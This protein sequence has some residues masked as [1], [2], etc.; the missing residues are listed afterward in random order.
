MT[1]IFFFRVLVYLPRE[2]TNISE[3]ITG[4]KELY[5]QDFRYHIPSTPNHRFR[6]SFN[7]DHLSIT[8]ASSLPHQFLES[9]LKPSVTSASFFVVDPREDEVDNDAVFL[10][11]FQIISSQAPNL[12]KLEIDLQYELILASHHL[13][14]MLTNHD[15]ITYLGIPLEWRA[16]LGLFPGKL[17]TLIVQYVDWDPNLSSI[18]RLVGKHGPGCLSDVKTVIIVKRL[19]SWKPEGSRVLEG[20]SWSR[21]ARRGR[22]SF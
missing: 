5:I 6:Y 2:L 4:L 7:L 14:T 9:L 21:C 3:F 22:W 17:S 15:Q 8:L 18:A 1:S 13:T 19:V 11:C 16:R 12:R 10:P 20:E